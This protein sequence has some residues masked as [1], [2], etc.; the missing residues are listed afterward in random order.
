MVLKTLIVDDEPIARRILRE[1]LE[2]IDEIALIGEAEDGASALVAIHDLSPDLVFLDLQMPGLGGF[3]VVRK[4]QPG[5]RIPLI[6]I[7]TAWDQY[8]IQAFEAGAID[9]L[10]KPIAQ[11]RLRQAV[12]RALKLRTRPAEV[13]QHFANVTEIA[14][15]PAGRSARR[16]VAKSGDE[17]L[18][19][20]A[21]EV[22]AFEA[23]RDLVWIVTAKKRYLAT[24]SL[25]VIQD[26]LRDT[27]F[28]RIHRRALV[29]IN[30]VRKMS[31]LSSQRWLLTLANNQ[32][33][34][35]VASLMKFSRNACPPRPPRRNTCGV[36]R[37]MSGYGQMRQRASQPCSKPIV[38]IGL[39]S[40]VSP[41]LVHEVSLQDNAWANSGA[42]ARP[43]PTDLRGEGGGDHTR[44]RIA[45]SHPRVVGAV[46]QRTFESASAGGVS[47][48]TKTLLGPA[49][50]GAWVFLCDSGRGG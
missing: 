2:Q 14:E 30:H 1:E 41:D 49:H 7:V 24:Q 42:C 33:R 31:M 32:E 39:R 25:K 36:K 35:A 48:I 19:L 26:K 20:N 34:I 17:Y 13:A 22:L 45:G 12:D 44:R 11:E 47:G 8:A 38:Q 10:L 16:I 18:L 23:D 3:E 21:D 9:Y 40:E 28:R 46:H 43:D 29:N 15:A 37:K 6:V 50:V 27:N 4:L 5:G